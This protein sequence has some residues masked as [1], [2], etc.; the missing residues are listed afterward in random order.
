MD[1]SRSPVRLGH[2]TDPGGATGCTVVL[3]PEGCV[4]SGEVRGGAPATREFELLDPRRMVQQVDAVVLTGGSAF[5][6]STA[7]G[8]VEALAEQDRGFETRAGRVPIVV[9]MA[10]FDLAEGVARPGPDEGRLA[11]QA[12]AEAPWPSGRVGAGAG[13][14]VGKWRGADHRVPSGIGIETV[15]AATPNGE[16]HVTAAIAVNAIGDIDDGSTVAEVLAGDHVPPT[17]PEELG[18]NTTIGVIW[19]NAILDKVGCRQ[20]AESG[21]DG[22]GRALLPAHTSGDGDALVAVSTGELDVPVATVR[23]LATVAVESAIRSCQNLDAS[24]R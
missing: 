23:L 13:A 17:D 10:L 3:F 7:H 8:V 2:W 20:V 11:L 22:F 15:R 21:H 24:G 4:A 14:T 1:D 19:T 18:E 5:G 9:A 16:L 12:A 6:L